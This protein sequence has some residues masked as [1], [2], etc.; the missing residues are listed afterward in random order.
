MSNCRWILAEALAGLALHSAALAGAETDWFASGC[1]SNPPPI[2]VLSTEP[3]NLI[4]RART[5]PVDPGTDEIVLA[6]PDGELWAQA[7]SF[8]AWGVTPNHGAS[9]VEGTQTWFRLSAVT[10][11]R[12][13]LDR[14][15][16]E[17]WLDTAGARHVAFRYAATAPR[18]A[19]A[20]AEEPG[21]FLNLDLQY[22][23]ASGV[24]VP[25]GLAEAGLFNRFGYGTQTLLHEDGRTARLETTWTRDRADVLQRLRIGDAITKAQVLG[26]S[27]RFGGVQ[28]GTDFSLQP[29]LVT[30]PLPAV[31]GIA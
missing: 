4:V 14:C 24:N 16:Q 7:P 15:T 3:Q 30:F 21:G 23:R 11:L 5:S 31:Q 27:V 1:D 18:E 6:T 29:D 22:L 9:R 28:W 13:R 20:V 12:S 8:A 25:S 19:I 10:G 2:E 17:L 26:R